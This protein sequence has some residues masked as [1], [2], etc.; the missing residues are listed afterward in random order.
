MIVRICM[1][2]AVLA[3]AGSCSTLG[4]DPFPEPIREPKPAVAVDDGTA[5]DDDDAGEDEG[6]TLS[7]TPGVVIQKQY[8]EGI[9][10]RLG[11]N[12]RGDPIRVSFHDVPLVPFINEV[13]GE[14]LGMSFSISPGLSEKT[15]LVTLRLTE[16]VPPSQ[17]FFTARRVL[18]DYGI[19]VGEQEGVLT[20]APTQEIGTDDIPLLISGRA[21]PEVP[22]T[23]R[24]IFQFVTLKV[25]RTV[26]VTRWLRQIFTG[27]DLGIAE[28]P[29]RNSLLLKGDLTTIAQA[30]E[31]IEVLDQPALRG[32]N[33]VIIE[34]QFLDAAAMANDITTLMEAEGYKV[35]GGGGFTSTMLIP[36]ES[37]NKLVAFATDPQILSHVEQWARTLDAEQQQQL[38]DAV[39]TYQVLHTQ[40][41]EMTETLNGILGISTGG[42]ERLSNLADEGGESEPRRGGSRSGRIVVDNNRNMLLFRGSG[43]EWGELL[44]V[45]KELDRPVPSVLIELLI[46]EVTLS[47]EERSGVEWMFRSTLG[48]GRS[49]SG[50]TLGRLGL[51]DKAFSLT[52]DSAGQTR[53]MLNF[54]YDDKRVMI[55]SRPRLLVKSGETATLEAGN[56]IPVVVQQSD[57]DTQLGGSTNVLQQ[58]SY[59]KTGVILEI[60]P[61]VQANGLV[62]LSISQE[63]S[64]ARPA[65]ATSLAGTPT[66]LNR[67]IST[68]LTL[69]DGGSLVMGGLISNTGSTGQAGVPGF[70][71]IPGLGRLFRSE[72]FL[73]D[74]T[75]LLIMVIPYVV[76]DFEEGQE[77]TERI[78][79]ELELHDQYMRGPADADT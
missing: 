75:E 74:R 9:A 64:E 15:D 42:G 16:P 6:F 11:Q 22:P 63:L 53:A 14:Q 52:L 18:Q 19:A 1:A 41:E 59:R 58:V 36:L 55:R 66:I 78:K 50:G 70:G 13:F 37:V 21:L 72:N 7:P 31:M 47:D 8:A 39:F 17:L 57:S 77:L 68:S 76:A 35:G 10:D 43:K 73:E 20:F 60:E 54:F 12:L 5:G 34:P 65:D 33:G 2:L 29:D 48:D 69:R 56:E 38:E 49:L 23:H 25:L 61:I 79:E 40:A 30:I 71:R 3:L 24:T 32:R 4:V 27:N 46:A 62:D 45:I 26:Q 44:A 51:Q 28:N 67:S